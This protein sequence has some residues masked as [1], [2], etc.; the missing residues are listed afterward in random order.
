M[1]IAKVEFTFYVMCPHCN[2]RNRWERI[3]SEAGDLLDARMRD[4]IGSVRG[5]TNI[6]ITCDL[7]NKQYTVDRFGL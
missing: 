3:I 4:I 2:R 5:E 6:E 7:C 1:A